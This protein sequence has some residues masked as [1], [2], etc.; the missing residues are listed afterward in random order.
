MR[1]AL[2]ALALGLLAT[3][4]Q[5]G[6][7]PQGYAPAESF[8]N[9]SYDLR[10]RVTAQVMLIAAGH[11]NIVPTELFQMKTFEAARDFQAANGLPATGIIDKPTFDRLAAETRPLFRMWDFREVAHPSR[12]HA[13]WI[14]QGMGLRRQLDKNG[15][16]FKEPGDRF[17]VSYTYYPGQ[18]IEKTYAW[19]TAKMRE[20]GT[21]V[22]YAV[23]KD[24]WFVISATTAAGFDEYMRYHE[25][26]TGVIGFTAFWNN[27]KGVVWG[28][29]IAILMSASL[30]SVMNGR[31]FVEPPNGADDRRPQVEA[32]DAARP[33][34]PVRLPRVE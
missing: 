24:G 31:P 11:Q 25:D 7:R 1:C 33:F 17:Q 29:R 15:L 30:G 10:N 6:P 16:T 9:D 19:L 5:A 12:G 18:W 22:H 21:T 28:E 8:F 34:A 3:S 14:P 27:D 13:I 20:R 26:G 2:V 32:V 4:V 23:I